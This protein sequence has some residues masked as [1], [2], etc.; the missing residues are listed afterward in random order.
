M[1]ERLPGQDDAL[2]PR[3][4]YAPRLSGFPVNIVY[5]ARIEGVGLAQATYVF[6]P[7]TFVEGE[8]SR[9]MRYRPTVDS[10]FSVLVVLHP[11]GGME[12]FKYRGSKGDLR[13]VRVGLSQRNDSHDRMRLDPRRTP[14]QARFSPA[15]M[16]LKTQA[17]HSP[18]GCRLVGMG[19][20]GMGGD[21]SPSASAPQI[22]FS[23]NRH[24]LVMCL[25]KR[26]IW[27]LSPDGSSVGLAQYRFLSFQK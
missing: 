25:G 1:A 12:T 18:L 6:D 21:L 10:D 11:E 24:L 3:N 5:A 9:Q 13:G 2:A 20:S 17:C 23:L 4:V 27:Y 15:T 22:F 8:Q 19:C 26:R 7:T 16:R 14:R